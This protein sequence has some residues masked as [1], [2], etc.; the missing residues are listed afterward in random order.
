MKE[1]VKFPLILDFTE[2]PRVHK[3]TQIH[4]GVLIFLLFLLMHPGFGS[5][6]CLLLMLRIPIFLIPFWK[7]SKIIPIQ[8]EGAGFIV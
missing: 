4:Q 1:V 2:N 6:I 5:A 3:I 8:L 7:E